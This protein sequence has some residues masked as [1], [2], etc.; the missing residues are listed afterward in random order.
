[1]A[2]ICDA[3]RDPVSVA[4]LMPLR[5]PGAWVLRG[6]PPSSAAGWEVLRD[7]SLAMLDSLARYGGRS[8]LL[9]AE[10]EDE[11]RWAEQLGGRPVDRASPLVSTP[12]LGGAPLE[13]DWFVVDLAEPAGPSSESW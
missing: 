8:V 2:T 1:L 9:A 3:G 13:V 4:V 5:A 6:S 10:D 11:A 7:G 12:L